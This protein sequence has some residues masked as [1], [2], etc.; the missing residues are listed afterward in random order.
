MIALFIWSYP[1]RFTCQFIRYAD[2]DAP[3]KV[4][5]SSVESAF[6][7]GK[8]TFTARE[9]GGGDRVLS[10]TAG[11]ACAEPKWSCWSGESIS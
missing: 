10:A 8:V 2:V 11:H 3:R 1:W 4:T 9:A 5:P 7:T 6:T